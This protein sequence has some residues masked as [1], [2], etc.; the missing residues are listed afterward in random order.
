MCSCGEMG[1]QH[2]NG[3]GSVARQSIAAAARTDHRCRGLG[4]AA[5]A[6][7]NQAASSLR[8][9]EAPSAHPAP[10]PGRSTPGPKPAGPAGVRVKALGGLASAWRGCS[11]APC[12]HKI[13]EAHRRPDRRG[14]GRQR[15]PG[16]P[17]LPLPPP[18]KARAS[19]CTCVC[20]R[21]PPTFCICSCPCL[22]VHRHADGVGAGGDEGPAGGRH[23]GWVRRDAWH[24]AWPPSPSTLMEPCR[25]AWCLQLICSSLNKRCRHCHTAGTLISLLLQAT[26]C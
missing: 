21:C 23:Q 26:R 8:A 1:A 11:E 17:P 16:S 15:A 12:R 19:G 18:P 6:A 10:P 24:G 22:K 5:P 9:S 13:G 3:E 4:A 25:L 7:R 14:E 20:R 2:G